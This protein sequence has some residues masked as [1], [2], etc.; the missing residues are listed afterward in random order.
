MR[1]I[2]SQR[3]VQPPIPAQRVKDHLNDDVWALQYLEDGGKF[4]VSVCHFY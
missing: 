1:E 4:E 2:E 3:F